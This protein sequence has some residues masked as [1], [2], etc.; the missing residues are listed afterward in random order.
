MHTTEF[1]D[2]A[3]VITAYKHVLIHMQILVIPS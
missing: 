3:T 1:P 2:E